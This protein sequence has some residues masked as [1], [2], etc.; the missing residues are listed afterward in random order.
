MDTQI[1]DFLNHG[2]SVD[3]IPT[4]ISGREPSLGPLKPDN[5][6]FQEPKSERTYVPEVVAALESRK[7]PPKP[8][9]APTNRRPRKKVIY[10]D[11]G[12][13]L[14]WEWVE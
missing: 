6:A 5:T 12:E 13:P 2:G 3:E 9:P 8:S 4:G 11:F 7:S 14:R 10:D 1:S